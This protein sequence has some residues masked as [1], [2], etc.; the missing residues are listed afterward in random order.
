MVVNV[1]LVNIMFLRIIVNKISVI[2][3]KNAFVHKHSSLLFRGIRKWCIDQ[4]LTHNCSESITRKP[5]MIGVSALIQINFYFVQL[6][7]KTK[8]IRLY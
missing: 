8:A 6:G 3:V 2:I 1:A 4:F 5:V 7:L